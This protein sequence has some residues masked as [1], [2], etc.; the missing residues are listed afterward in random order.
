MKNTPILTVSTEEFSKLITKSDW[1]ISQRHKILSQK[2]E[3]LRFYDLDH[4]EVRGEYVRS[5]EGVLE[6]ECISNDVRVII[7]NS[8][9]FIE[10]WYDSF[11]FT[12]IDPYIDGI[13]IIDSFTNQI[14]NV[15]KFL[16]E[17]GN[18]FNKVDYS[19]LSLTEKGVVGNWI[20]DGE[21]VFRLIGDDTPLR[22]SGEHIEKRS[23]L[24]DDCIGHFDVFRTEKGSFVVNKRYDSK[25]YI[26]TITETKTCGTKE[27]VESFLK[28]SPP[29]F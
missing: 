26:D 18:F 8:F 6:K 5:Y 24:Y 12:A 27:E 4:N 3:Y 17:W 7:I 29:D 2:E 23:V 20:N 16:S 11:Y 9:R 19:A 10:N 1:Y 25:H 14:I 13:A 15:D 28:A 22:F 21:R